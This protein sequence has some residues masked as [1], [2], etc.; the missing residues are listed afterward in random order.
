MA[1][2]IRDLRNLD[3]NLNYFIGSGLAASG[4]TIH[5]SYNDTRA[6]S[7]VY[8]IDGYPEEPST[9]KA[10]TVVIELLYTREDPFQL[11]PG[12]AVRS[13]FNIEVFARTDAERDDLGDLVRSFLNQ[14]MPIYDY[15]LVFTNNQY[16]IVT[17][18]DFENIMMRTAR[19]DLDAEWAKHVAVIQTDVVYYINTGENLI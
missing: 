19:Y 2:K 6:T 8:L 7:G 17:Y 4:Y 10:P 18:A 14:R 16:Q 3:I 5:R 9:V 15:N 1:Y 12:K 11:G 13:R